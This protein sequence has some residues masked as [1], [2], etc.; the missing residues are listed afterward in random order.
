M[1]LFGGRGTVVAAMQ[2]QRVQPKIL[3]FL[4]FFIRTPE[5]LNIGSAALLLISVFCCTKTKNKIQKWTHLVT[6]FGFPFFS[7][8]FLTFPPFFA[9]AWFRHSHLCLWFAF[10]QNHLYQVSQRCF[11]QND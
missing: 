7:F 2:K 5:R 9:D 10:S 1:L 6:V 3:V 4:I 11:T 8:F